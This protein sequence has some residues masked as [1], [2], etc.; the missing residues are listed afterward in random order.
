MPK[1]T[2]GKG[3]KKPAS[4]EEEEEPIITVVDKTVNKGIKRKASSS[5]G[6]NVKKVSSINE[7]A[8][9][10]TTQEVEDEEIQLPRTM[11]LKTSD[12]LS[13]KGEKATLKLASWNLNGIRAWLKGDG[14]K[15]IEQEQPDM[16]CFQELKCDKEKIPNE[17]TPT[18]YKSYWLSGD[19]AGY[20][21]VGLLTKI[22]PIEVKFGI[23]VP[24]HDNE[25]RVITAEYEKFYF[26]VSYIPNS[27]RK[28]VRLEYRQEFNE[29]FRN[30]L[31]E[32]DKKKPVIWCGDL[33]VSH[34]SID[35]ANAKS[36][37]KTAGYTQEERDDFTKI[38]AD[39]FIDSFRHLYPEQRDAY[40]FWSYFRSARDRNIGWRLDYFI[41]SSRLQENL[42]DVIHQTGV[43]GS[44][45][46]PIVLLL[47]V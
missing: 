20:S 30:Y 37:T 27:G 2:R 23:G 9:T 16:I 5:V 46:C 8:T 3:N 38:L 32:L 11:T 41:I 44:D 13:T 33:N 28:L 6:K 19:T 35:L 18:G 14:L 43:Y 47:S 36:N 29:A 15:Y 24:E 34:Q 1:V 17:A 39:G 45:H 7:E 31:K 26:V 4:I 42:C 10:G 22:D 12:R 21:G 40:T 25:G